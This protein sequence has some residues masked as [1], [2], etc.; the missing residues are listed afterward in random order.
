M[1]V[2]VGGDEYLREVIA[3]D[4]LSDVVVARLRVVIGADG[5]LLRATGSDAPLAAGSVARLGVAAALDRFARQPP[6]AGPATSAPATFDGVYRVTGVTAGLIAMGDQWL[7]PSYVVALADGRT[8]T[9]L[10]IEPS[11]VPTG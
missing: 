3:S 11:D 7:V 1:E 8:M 6:S 5:R 2:T 10:A 4:N 9:L